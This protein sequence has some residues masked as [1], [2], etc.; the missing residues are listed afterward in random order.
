MSTYAINS[1]FTTGVS[2]FNETAIW[3]NSSD[4]SDEQPF[5]TNTSNVNKLLPGI[6]D[7]YGPNVPVNVKISIK[8]IEQITVVNAT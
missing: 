6:E 2:I 1:F 3:V 4:V 5:P 8:K 7:Y